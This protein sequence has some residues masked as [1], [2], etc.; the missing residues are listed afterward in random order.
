M[1]DT[2]LTERPGRGWTRWAE[3]V[4][5]YEIERTWWQARVLHFPKLN[6]SV[7]FDGS[8]MVGLEHWGFREPKW[9]MRIPPSD[10]KPMPAGYRLESEQ[11]WLLWHAA[12]G[13]RQSAL[14]PPIRSY[15]RCRQRI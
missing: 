3:G 7:W 13:G 11:V 2:E 12:T 15:R 14:R 8:Q 9:C 4:G 1:R 5:E 6:V 10:W